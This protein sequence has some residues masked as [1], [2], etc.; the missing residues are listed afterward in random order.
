V[1][2]FFFIFVAEP[3][4]L[5][6]LFVETEAGVV[7][8]MLLVRDGTRARFIRGFCIVNS[9]EQQF[10]I[11]GCQTL[12]PKCFK[13]TSF[14]AGK[15]FTK[16]NSRNEDVEFFVP[17]RLFS[18]LFLRRGGGSRRWRRCVLQFSSLA[19]VEECEE[20]QHYFFFFFYLFCAKNVR[21]PYYYH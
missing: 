1:T 2:D 8:V 3:L 21:N 9:N 15:N 6:R 19:V 16:K 14:F 13:T 11:L 7:F 20:E 17:R 18:F 10:S 5:C 12:Y 4:P